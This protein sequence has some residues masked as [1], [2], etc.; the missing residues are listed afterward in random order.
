MKFLP[1]NKSLDFPI[2]ERCTHVIRYEQTNNIG[3]K[4][5]CISNVATAIVLLSTLGIFA[6]SLAGLYI[7]PTFL[8]CAMVLAIIDAIAFLFAD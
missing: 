7:N 4:V 3:K 2:N 1:K 8:P 6:L 5:M